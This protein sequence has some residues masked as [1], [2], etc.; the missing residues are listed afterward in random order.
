[1]YSQR[2]S[3]C[4]A[5]SDLPQFR[6]ACRVSTL[7][8]VDCTIPNLLRCVGGLQDEQTRAG[9]DALARDDR[10]GA[11]SG[12]SVPI[13]FASC[14]SEHGTHDESA[15]R[16]SRFGFIGVGFRRSGGVDLFSFLV[17]S[18]FGREMGL[19]PSLHPREA[20]PASLCPDPRIC[21]TGV[22]TLASGSGCRIFDRS[23]LRDGLA[24]NFRHFGLERKCH[25]R[26][27]LHTQS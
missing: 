20:A 27:L 4:V 3:G 6:C 2:H 8:A 18:F 19:M 26:P 9:R 12:T 13:A 7:D 5:K 15:L 16:P 25:P 22:Y 23:E 17:H 11:L 14:C 24:P 10:A 21:D 1:M